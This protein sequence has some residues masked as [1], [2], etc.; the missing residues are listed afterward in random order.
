MRCSGIPTHQLYLYNV[1]Y[2][3][4]GEACNVRAHTPR[5][6]VVTAANATAL[7]SRLNS[8]RAHG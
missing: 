6:P 7:V 3:I 4:I 2:T 8:P 1:A 5:Q